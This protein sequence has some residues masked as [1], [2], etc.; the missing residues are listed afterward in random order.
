MAFLRSSGSIDAANGVR[1]KE[2]AK[3][4]KKGEK[5]ESGRNRR[6]KGRRKPGRY[7]LFSARTAQNFFASLCSAKKRASY[8]GLL[9]SLFFPRRNKSFK[10]ERQEVV[11]WNESVPR[12]KKESGTRNRVGDGSGEANRSCRFPSGARRNRHQQRKRCSPLPR[13][14][15]LRRKRSPEKKSRRSCS[16]TEERGEQKRERKAKRISLFLARGSIRP[17]PLPCLATG[18]FPLHRRE[19]VVPQD[20]RP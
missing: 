4:Q 13:T 11:P 20:N 18:L 5:K 14:R 8:F 2:K 16:T 19:P 6:R 1:K 12:E 3:T 10:G 7:D 15:P 9:R 17:I